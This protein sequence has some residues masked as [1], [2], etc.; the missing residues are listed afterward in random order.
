MADSLAMTARSSAAVLHARTCRMRSRNLSD[1]III[2]A[3]RTLI[4]FIRWG[5]NTITMMT[6]EAEEI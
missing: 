4:L 3:A 6:T 2:D 1:M 5:K